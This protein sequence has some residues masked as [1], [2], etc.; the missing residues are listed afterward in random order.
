M[1]KKLIQFSFLFLLCNLMMGQCPGSKTYFVSPN[2]SDSNPGTLAQPFASMYH[3]TKVLQAGDVAIFEN[4]QYSEPQFV[5][6]S[7]GGT[8]NC[9]ITI[10]ARNKHQAVV[11]F[12]G[13]NGSAHSAQSINIIK[14]HIIVEGFDLSKS[15]KGTT[16]SNQII[17]IYGRADFNEFGNYVTIRDNIIHNAFEEG[18]KS[19]RTKGIIVENNIIYDFIHE[20]IDFVSVDE[21]IIREMKSMMSKELVS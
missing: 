9:P 7:N 15:V 11:T 14:P 5:N 16:T 6:F 21:S 4:G 10:K 12:I 8:A 17:R 18:V 20:G 13:G 19:H 1:F 3:V 2:G